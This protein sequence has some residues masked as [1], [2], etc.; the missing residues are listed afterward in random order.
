MALLILIKSPNIFYW[1][2]AKKIKVGVVL[3]KNLG[4]I[5][6]NVVKKSREMG[7]INSF[8]HISHGEYMLKQ[9]VVVVQTPE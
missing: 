9:K 7:I 1:K 5:R 4:Q 6:P 2:P 3:G 8:F